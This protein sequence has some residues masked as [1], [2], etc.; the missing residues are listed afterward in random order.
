[1]HCFFSK[2][3][4]FKVNLLHNKNLYIIIFFCFSISSNILLSQNLGWEYKLNTFADNREYF[5]EY[6]YPQSILGLSNSFSLQTQIDTFHTINTGIT[7][8]ME[9]GADYNAIP[10]LPEIYYRFKNRKSSI[11]IGSF[12]RQE[13]LKYPSA[14]LTDTLNYFRP[15][16]QGGLARINGKW[17]FQQ[18]WIDWTGRQTEIVKEEFITGI[19]GR[20]Q[21]GIFY[22]ENYIFMSHKAFTIL[23]TEDEHIQDNY[24]L[25]GYVGANLSSYTILDSLRVDFGMIVSQYRERPANYNVSQGITSRL[26]ARYKK[27]GLDFIYY[28]GEALEFVWGDK[29]YTSKNYSRT[30]I[31]W[32][33]LKTKNVISELK[34]CV[35]LVNGE[36]N[37]SQQILI[38]IKINKEKI[39]IPERKN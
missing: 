5:N 14:I 32:L 6:S 25:S 24:G 16:I 11:Y 38:N 21:K 39:N 12:P 8:I 19:N 20:L 1:M 29:I 30:D 33:P 23:K 3:Q 17:G 2:C 18:M 36:V 28:T 26:E 22:I 35:H 15:N 7:Y 4:I 31:I 37:Y 10:I 34:F 27:I 9:Y 13:L